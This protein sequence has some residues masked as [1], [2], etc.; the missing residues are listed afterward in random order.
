[1]GKIKQILYLFW[2]GLLLSAFAH[3][4]LAAR[5]IFHADGERKIATGRE[6]RGKEGRKREREERATPVADR[7]LFMAIASAAFLW[8]KTIDSL[9]LSLSPS[10]PLSFSRPPSSS[11]ALKY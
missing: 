9:S 6:K 5:F 8:G 2:K 1:M 4:R 3:A 10:F 7:R 11:L